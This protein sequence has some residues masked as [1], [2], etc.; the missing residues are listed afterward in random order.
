MLDQVTPNSSYPTPVLAIIG[1]GRLGTVLAR[2]L[3]GK[4]IIY[5]RKE[6]LAQQLAQTCAGDWAKDIPALLAKISGLQLVL[7]ILALPQKEIRP[8]L[9]GLDQQSQLSPLKTPETS[10]QASAGS[11]GRPF[12]VER[13]LFLNVATAQATAELKAAFPAWRFLG[14]KFVGHAGEMENDRPLIV[15]SGAAEEDFAMVKNVFQP[16]GDVTSG[17]EEKVQQLNTLVTR[18]VLL[19]ARDL[20]K[21]VVGAEL[22]V[23]WLP[24]A[25]RQVAAGVLRAYARGDLGPFARSVLQESEGLAPNDSSTTNHGCSGNSVGA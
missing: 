7:F 20:E 19:L 13:S 6:D 9:Q 3:P 4:K 16:L 23:A 17:P 18:E 11:N 22:P 24:Y 2:R 25:L 21:K 15:V 1:A 14:V 12:L 8:F 10:A 5:D